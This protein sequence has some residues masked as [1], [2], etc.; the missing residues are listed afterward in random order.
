[1]CGRRW[2]GELERAK[3]VRKNKSTD[4]PLVSGHSAIPLG[5]RSSSVP[6]RLRGYLEHVLP[7]LATVARK[8]VRADEAEAD[9]AAPAGRRQ[10]PRCSGERK[11]HQNLM[12]RPCQ[13]C[14]LSAWAMRT[15]P[16]ISP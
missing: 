7:S 12:I 9:Y 6:L 11:E 4:D 5:E 14:L 3:G 15:L 13:R 10:G 8:E 1:M 16:P 2:Q